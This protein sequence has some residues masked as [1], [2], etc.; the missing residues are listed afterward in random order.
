M[1]LALLQGQ[2]PARQLAHGRGDAIDDEIGVLVDQLQEG[3]PALGI[4]CSATSLTACL[5]FAKRR[6]GS[7]RDRY[8]VCVAGGAHGVDAGKPLCRFVGLVALE[9]NALPLPRSSPCRPIVCVV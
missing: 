4:R 6:D 1:A 2:P 9:L 3:V 8:R 5:R 7:T